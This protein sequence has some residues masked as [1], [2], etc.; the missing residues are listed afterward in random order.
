MKFPIEQEIHTS[1]II[2]IKSHSKQI[3]ILTQDYKPCLVALN[4][5]HIPLEYFHA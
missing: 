1:E 4:S 2:V 3:F 5:L